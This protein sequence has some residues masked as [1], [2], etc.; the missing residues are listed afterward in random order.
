[1]MQTFDSH[2]DKKTRAIFTLFFTNAISEFRRK[3]FTI[4]NIKKRFSLVSGTCNFRLKN[5]VGYLLNGF[6]SSSYELALIRISLQL[7]TI[8]LSCILCLFLLSKLYP[9]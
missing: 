3:K 4:S 6:P 5:L 2:L 9:H 1:M 7:I 8:H